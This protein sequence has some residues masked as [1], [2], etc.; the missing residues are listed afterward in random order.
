L[1]PP[2]VATAR[3]LAHQ[4]EPGSVVALTLQALV[5]TVVVVGGYARLRRGRG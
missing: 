5:W 3:V 1:V 2:L 4:P